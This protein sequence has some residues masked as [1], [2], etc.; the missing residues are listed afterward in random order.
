[1]RPRSIFRSICPIS[2]YISQTIERNS[3]SRGTKKSLL[4][5][6]IFILGMD[7]N[8]F[9]QVMILRGSGAFSLTRPRVDFSS[10]TSDLIM[11]TVI[12]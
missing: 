10:P 8:T 12:K 7:V 4:Y 2:R 9:L 6:W 1:M 5:L 3:D 11:Y